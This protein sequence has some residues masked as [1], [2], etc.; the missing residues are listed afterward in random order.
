MT[1]IY[2]PKNSSLLTSFV[3]DIFPVL[4]AL[5]G[6]H[7]MHEGASSNG[8]EWLLLVVTIAMCLL[9]VFLLI[10]TIAAHSQSVT[11]EEDRISITGFLGATAI[12]FNSIDKAVLRERVNPVSRTDHLLI[13]QSRNGQFLTFNSSTLSPEDE[14]DF[15]TELRKHVDLEVVRDKPVL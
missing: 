2:K 9:S 11:L 12:S 10:Q 3:W 8:L 6:C 15:L 7:F 13:I 1:R 14:E 5:I 4:I